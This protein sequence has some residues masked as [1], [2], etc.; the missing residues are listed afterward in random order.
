[1]KTTS[2]QKEN[3]MTREEFKRLA[4]GNYALNKSTIDPKEMT[5][6]VDGALYTFDYFEKKNVKEKVNVPSYETHDQIKG[7]MVHQ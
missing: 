1:V 7:T 2:Q 5:N 4:A 3:N 6:Y